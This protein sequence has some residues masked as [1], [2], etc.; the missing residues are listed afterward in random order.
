MAGAAEPVHGLYLWL[1][2]PA[3]EALPLRALILELS[4]R[5]GAP[6]FEP[7]LTL[8]GPVGPGAADEAQRLATAIAPLEL[9]L[10]EVAGEP[11]F[12][13][14]LY[15]RVEATAPLLAARAQ[16]QARFGAAS[17]FQPHLSFVYGRLDPAA[18]AQLA[19]ALAPRLP[20]LV[21]ARHLDLI[22]TDGVPSQWRRLARFDLGGEPS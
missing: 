3:D 21:T 22:R 11:S 16:A 8:L 12:Y 6:A 15:A 5:L 10:Q 9:R 14:C 19:A 2:P 4:G 13:R 1:C 7:H 20:A 18:R 17:P